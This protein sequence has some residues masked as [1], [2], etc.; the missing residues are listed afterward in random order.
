VAIVEDNQEYRE[1]LET[2][3]RHQADFELAGAYPSAELALAEARRRPGWDLVLMDVE[4]PGIDGIEATRR[5]R[6]LDPDVAVVALTVFE[7]P[8]VVLEAISAGVSGYV[9]KNTG[10]RELAAQLRS[11]LD[12]GAPLSPAVAATLLEFVRRS[13]DG[14]RREVSPTRLDLTDR[15]TDVLR[16][17]V[18]GR[19]YDQTGADLGISASTVRTHVRALY[20]KLQV[21]S[22][23]EA[24]RKAVRSG[25]C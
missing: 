16:R 14:D 15:E 9:L 7:S 5:L 21:H 17:L 23:A 24:V 25:L 18:E 22:V 11:V 10:A 6:A 20:R 12:G 8:R 1:T 19:T 4:L 2:F 13:G 3:V